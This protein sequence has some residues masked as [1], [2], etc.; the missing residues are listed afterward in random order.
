MQQVTSQ[1]AAVNEALDAIRLGL[2]LHQLQ[3]QQQQ[4]QKQTQ[5]GDAKFP[6]N[7][8]ELSQFFQQHLLRLAPASISAPAIIPVPGITTRAEAVVVPRPGTVLVPQNQ[9][10][11]N[12]PGSTGQSPSI[13]NGQP[14]LA[15]PAQLA[16]INVVPPNMAA[17][18]ASIAKPGEVD[19]QTITPNVNGV[20]V[21]QPNCAAVLRPSA[22]VVPAGA[23]AVM[24]RRRRQNDEFEDRLDL[25]EDGDEDEDLGSGIGADCSVQMNHGGPTPAKR[26]LIVSPAPNP[27]SAVTYLN[28]VATVSSRSA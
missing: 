2:Q 21:G 4:T 6:T 9:S 11:P 12:V 10:T 28:P 25:V 13:M 27:P 18:A 5:N 8:A 1:A 16:R 3:Q 20:T 14:A 7:I 22:S 23:A 24:L 15:T 26:P 17:T 19:T